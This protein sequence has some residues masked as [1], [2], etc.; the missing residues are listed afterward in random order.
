MLYLRVY[1]QVLSEFR[2]R[3]YWFVLNEGALIDRLRY[4]WRFNEHSYRSGKVLLAEGEAWSQQA[5]R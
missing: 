5:K 1:S 3:R 4:G 2:S